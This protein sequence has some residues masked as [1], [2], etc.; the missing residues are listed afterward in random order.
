MTMTR[1]VQSGN[2]RV[3]LIPK[4]TETDQEENCLSKVGDICIVCPSKDP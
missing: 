4:E 2:T 3:L 1:I